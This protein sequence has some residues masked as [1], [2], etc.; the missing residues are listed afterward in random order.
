MSTA[1]HVHKQSDLRVWLARSCLVRLARMRR[2]RVSAPSADDVMIV[3]GPRAA[4]IDADAV[5][6]SLLRL[7]ARAQ[8]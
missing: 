1:G 3:M 5:K 8:Q 2:S 6:P 4:Y 7:L